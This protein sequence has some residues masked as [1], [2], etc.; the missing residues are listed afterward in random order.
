MSTHQ[1]HA[2]ESNA[3]APKPTPQDPP[4]ENGAQ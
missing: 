3:A 1:D 2:Q 4:P